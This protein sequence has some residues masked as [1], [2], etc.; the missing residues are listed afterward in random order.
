MATTDVTNTLI[1]NITSTEQSSSNIPI[2]RSNGNPQFNA[3]VGQFTT[4]FALGA[5]ANVITLPFSP[6]TQVYIKNIDPVKTI[7]VNWTPNGGA[8]ANIK[9]LNIGDQII[10]WD[11]PAGA[12]TPGITSLTLT[13]SA[14]GCLVEYFLGG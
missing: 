6:V 10:S 8:P 7:T 3:N 12:I 9:V 11:N 2:N 1:A 4:Y 14:A 13:P 5:G